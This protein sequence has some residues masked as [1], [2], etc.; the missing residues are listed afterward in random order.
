MLSFLDNGCRP[1]R[2]ETEYIMKKSQLALACASALAIG[3]LGAPVAQAQQTVP[4]ASELVNFEVTGQD[5]CELDVKITNPTNAIY[6]MD[7]LL[8]GQVLESVNGSYPRGSDGP[9]VDP[10]G[11]DPHWPDVAFATHPDN[12]T[13]KN[14]TIDF[15]DQ[16]DGVE[17]DGEFVVMIR[18]RR[19]PSSLHINHIARDFNPYTI[20]GCPTSDG[21]GSLDLGSITQ[22]SLGSLFDS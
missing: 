2:Q 20:T 9:V 10:A 21:S 19:G 4:A 12:P 15:T 14:A 16:L 7:Y 17:H 13:V 11:D 3:A 22:G 1:R 8:P 6:R 18:I 5:N